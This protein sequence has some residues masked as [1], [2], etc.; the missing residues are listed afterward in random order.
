MARKILDL[1]LGGLNKSRFSFHGGYIGDVP[2]LHKN[3]KK[4]W[5]L[6]VSQKNW[7]SQSVLETDTSWWF[8]PIWKIL[9]NMDLFPR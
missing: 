3:E 1:H 7:E 2:C 8:Q 9:V 4:T 5:A 6:E